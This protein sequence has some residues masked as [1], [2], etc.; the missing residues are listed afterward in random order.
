MAPLQEKSKG[1]DR[2]RAQKLLPGNAQFELEGSDGVL[3]PSLLSGVIVKHTPTFSASGTKIFVPCGRTALC[4]SV[5]TAR[6]TSALPAHK[7]KVLTVCAGPAFQDCAEPLA[8]GTED[9]EV[10]LWDGKTLACLGTLRRSEKPVLGLRWPRPDTIFALRGEKWKRPA[11]VQQIDVRQIASPQVAGVVPMSADEVCG[12][13]VSDNAVVLLDGSD[14]CVWLEGWPRCVRYSHNNPLSAVSIDPLRRYVAVGDVKGVIWTWWGCLD[15]IADQSEAAKRIPAKYHWHSSVVR[16]LAHVGPIVLSGGDEGVLVVRRS[17]TDVPQFVPRFGAR[18]RFIATA[19]DGQRLCV[20]LSDNSVAIVENLHSV[21]KPRWIRASAMPDKKLM[22]TASVSSSQRAAGL[23]RP[24]LHSVSSAA[25]GL[26]SSGAGNCLQFLDSTGHVSQSQSVT[27]RK[28]SGA[29]PGNKNPEQRWALWQVA[30]NARGTAIM[31]CERR[32]SPALNRFDTETAEGYIIK[33]W[34]RENES[35]A[36]VLDSMA[37]NPHTA[38]ITVALAHPQR[39]HVFVTGSVDGSFKCWDW[40]PTTYDGTQ[41][42]KSFSKRCWQLTT[43][44]TWHGRPILSGSFCMDG[45]VLALGFRGFVVLWEPEN[46]V[47]LEVLPLDVG[48]LEAC[49]LSFAMLCGH[50]A[51]LAACKDKSAEQQQ[52]LCWDLLTF[53]VLARLDVS[54]EF[55]GRGP[56][57]MRAPQS[58]QDVQS[59]PVVLFHESEQLERKSDGAESTANALQVW[60]LKKDASASRLQFSRCVATKLSR[61]PG[62]LDATFRAGSQRLVCL[63]GDFEVAELDV[64]AQ[65]DAPM[66]L[67]GLLEEEMVAPDAKSKA[68]R[69]LGGVATDLAMMNRLA[70]SGAGRL[71]GFARQFR[72]TAAQQAGIVNRVLSGVLPAHVPSHLL[73]SP[74]VLFNGLLSVFAKKLPGMESPQPAL[75]LGKAGGSTTS[76]S[77][78]TA[79]GPSKALASLPPWVSADSGPPKPDFVTADWMDGLI[80][81]AFK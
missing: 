71:K 23:R 25:A 76:E 20:S 78:G 24:M 59:L 22:G 45:S 36:F 28:V 48:S 63:M 54:K 9:G 41:I 5:K 66:A 44:G 65:G 31:T 26:A 21:V 47:E 15:G 1:S 80:K 10:R 46:A 30:F 2:R 55:P 3:I 39:E 73:P 53:Q 7:S 69:L 32:L 50:F 17:D 57:A 56:C 62:L 79:L 6:Q 67:E 13:D 68:A 14:L 35:E 8:T 33:W 51:L 81:E 38:E 18:M 64:F 29:A 72:V 75:Q 16:A 27:L 11:E 70:K 42:D 74:A 37:N 12:W 34:R 43:S 52:L 58:S 77:E 61:P 4:Y 19:P 40:L 49:Q 60:E